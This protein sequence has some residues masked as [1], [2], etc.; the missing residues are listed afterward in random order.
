MIDLHMHSLYSDGT[1]TTNELVKMAMEKNMKLISLT[2][3]DTID[4]L[5]EMKKLCDENNIKCIEKDFYHFPFENI[6][7]WNEIIGERE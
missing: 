1:S 2:G 5:S 4:G 7:D 6:K 3:H